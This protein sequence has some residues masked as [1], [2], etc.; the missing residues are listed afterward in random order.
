MF[1]RA[2]IKVSIGRILELSYSKKKGVTTSLLTE[3]KNF[4]IKIDRNGRVKIDG[5]AG[6]ITF[7]GDPALQE[8]GAKL[9]MAS[10]TFREG[11]GG[12]IE[13]EATYHFYGS[14]DI[15]VSGSFDPFEL[16]ETC[17]GLLCQAARA[18]NADYRKN[19]IMKRVM[20]D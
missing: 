13:Y 1:N 8:L 19:K 9:K 5:S 2:N 12:N 10:I 3:T 11:D 17:S 4:K 7:G 6:I 14:V 18:I 20:V 16:V 15:A